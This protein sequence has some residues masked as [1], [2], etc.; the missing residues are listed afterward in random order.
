MQQDHNPQ[1][2][3]S[4][5]FIV[6]PWIPKAEISVTQQHMGEYL[7]SK[8]KCH[9]EQNWHIKL[10]ILQWWKRRVWAFGP[11]DETVQ[12]MPTCH[13]RKPVVKPWLHLRSQFYLHMPPG[14]NRSCL[15]VS[16]SLPPM[17]HSWNEWPTPG[18]S[19]WARS[20]SALGC[21]LVSGN[22]LCLS[23]Y[24]HI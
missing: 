16:W 24:I 10:S 13:I 14:S 21:E 17:W 19:L 4:V 1:G 7:G 12:E 9:S 15:K 5:L 18:F 22:F 23:N 11:R 3:K 20:F 8:S 2:Q 6:L